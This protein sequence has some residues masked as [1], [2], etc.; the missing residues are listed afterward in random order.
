MT[1]NNDPIN[2]ADATFSWTASTEPVSGYKIHYGTTSRNYDFVVD[3]GLPTPVNGEIVASVDGLLEG[4]TYYFAATAYSATE[5]SDYSVEVVYSVN[6]AANSEPPVAVDISLQG[7]ED[8]PLSGQLEA[9]SSEG[10][11]LQFTVVSQPTHGTL[12]VEDTTGSFSY[13]PISNYFGPDA[14]SYTAA[15]SAGASNTATVT[16]TI[17]SQRSPLPAPHR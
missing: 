2:G 15:N 8:N 9:S 4:Q 6:G 10:T 13:T 1:G 7:P 14:F 11:S 16:L 12:T 17:I 3:V 5:E